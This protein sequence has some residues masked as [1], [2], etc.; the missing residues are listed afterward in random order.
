ML[1]REY[2]PVIVGGVGTHVQELARGLSALGIE[3]HVFAVGVGSATS[4]RDGKVSVQYVALPAGKNGKQYKVGLEEASSLNRRGAAA[5]EEYFKQMSKRPSVVHIHDWFPFEAADR[6]RSV[7]ETP[8]LTTIHTLNSALFQSAPT[9]D[10]I[11]LEQRRCATELERRCCHGSD[12]IIAVSKSVAEDLERIYSVPGDGINVV[13]NG[14]DITRFL[15]NEEGPENCHAMHN[16]WLKEG[17]RR[18]V[19]AGRLEPHK[20]VLP[21]LR[22]AR[23]VIAKAGNVR[24]LIAGALRDGQ[25]LNQ[26]RSVVA[27]DS[28]LSEKVTFVGMLGRGQLASLYKCSTL[29]VVPSLH[30][31]FGYAAIEPMAVGLPVVATHVGGLGEII[32]HD[33]TGIL[34]PTTTSRIEG[35]RD[36]DPTK[37]AEAQLELLND[38]AKA[39]RLGKEAQRDVVSRFGVQQMVEKTLASYMAAVNCHGCVAARR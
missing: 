22:S 33:R 11:E 14:F 17:E 10:A 15:A 37:L 19:F 6:L 16:C 21:L 38:P 28:M 29:A 26:L 1:T 4:Y 25:Y 27:E 2:P 30:E 23:Q 13:W 35:A 5:V 20:G 9:N 24:Y 7:F 18:I 34:V 39:M 8:V 32:V 3:V 12:R 36:L 31:P